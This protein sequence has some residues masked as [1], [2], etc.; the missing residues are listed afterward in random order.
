M[1]R[2][3]FSVLALLF[4]SSIHANSS[5]LQAG[6]LAEIQRGGTIVIA[7]E[8]QYPPFNYFENKKVVGFEVDLANQIAEKMKL[9]PEWK[10]FAFDSLLIGLQNKRYD[11]VIASHGITA[12]R[13]K[14]V[15]FTDPYYCSG[16]AIL[17]HPGGPKTLADLKGKR[18]G[19]GVGT[20]YAKVISEMKD[21]KGITFPNDISSVQ[22]L[23]SNKVDA[24]VTDK[25]V[26]LDL[27]KQ[28][29]L[30]NTQIGD[31]IQ[32][33]RVAMAVAKGNDTLKKAVNEAL[34]ALMK[35]GTYARLSQKY[36]NQDIRCR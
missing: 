15:D 3:K 16:G 24:I 19:V 13:E 30:P 5:P 11:L 22:G 17:S 32:Q 6:T 36:F 25:F 27:Q 18:V 20:S 26:L 35:D 34:Q 7:T 29:K 8:G 14:A 12:E 23:V 1:Y 28:G 9:K 2:F 33:E 21:L 10:T 4:L 31:F